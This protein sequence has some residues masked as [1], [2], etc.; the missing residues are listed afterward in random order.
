MQTVTVALGPPTL[1]R[2]Y[3][4]YVGA[5]LMDRAGALISEAGL[6]NKAVIITD[7]TVGRLYGDRL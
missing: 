7:T 5:G 3:S 2:T 6:S 4:I 1:G